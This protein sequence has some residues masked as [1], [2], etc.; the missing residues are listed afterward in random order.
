MIRNGIELEKQG[1][2]YD[3]IVATIKKYTTKTEMYLLP[4][5]FGQLKNSGRV[6]TA[7]AIFATL[8]NINLLLRFENG[9]V[10]IAEKIRTK[11]RAEN[12]LLQI[13]SDAIKEYNLKEICI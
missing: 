11:K 2:T 8:L 5:S 10:V 1:K 7:Q 12:K 3:E 13:I 6:T 4:E 9:K